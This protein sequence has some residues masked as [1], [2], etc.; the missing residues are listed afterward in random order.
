MM[1]KYTL[2]NAQMEYITTRYENQIA[3]EL[4][5]YDRIVLT[6]T[7]LSCCYAEGMERYLGIHKILYY[8]FPEQV[9]KPLADKI[10]AH[11]TMIAE[12]AGL[13]IE[14]LGRS[15]IRKEAFVQEKV[16]KHG[17][18][19]GLVCILSNVEACRRFM[20]YHDKEK[21]TYRA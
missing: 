14:Y 9:A 15:S 17:N 5:C 3:G 1:T 19:P 20:P 8:D 2:E 16:V 18:K 10:K 12:E 11:A 4:T 7:L 13:E 21:K 6:G